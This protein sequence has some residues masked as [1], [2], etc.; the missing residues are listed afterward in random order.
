MLSVQALPSDSYEVTAQVTGTA[1]A[2]ASLLGAKTTSGGVTFWPLAADVTLDAG[3]SATLRYVAGVTG[4]AGALAPGA[5]LTW[6]RTPTNLSATA[7]VTASIISPAGYFGRLWLKALGSAYQAPDG[8]VNASDAL[9]LGG[10]LAAGRATNLAVR[11]EMFADSVT[12][13]LPEWEASY[14]LAVRPDLSAGARQARLLAKVR[15]SRAGTPAGILLAVRTLA[16]EATLT[17]NTAAAVAATNPRNVFRY[18]VT[19]TA[20]HFADADL[21]GQVGALLAA[22]QPAHTD[23]TLTTR[24]GFRCD[25]P[26]SLVDRDCLGS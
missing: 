5:T 4:A 24:V 23:H 26:L 8:S 14:G 13:L 25:D 18:A 11:A 21:A 12:Q 9:A 2:T 20:A 10:A 15:A 7:T 16:P 22:M 17:E 19:I 3:G 1:N 6:A